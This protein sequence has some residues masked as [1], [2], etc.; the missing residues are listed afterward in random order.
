MLDVFKQDAFSTV[1]LTDSIN[2][3][4]YK[5]GRLG[6]LK[7]FRSKGIKDKVAVEKSAAGSCR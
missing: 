2:K 4:P 5:P 1:S 3:A 6:A 7:L